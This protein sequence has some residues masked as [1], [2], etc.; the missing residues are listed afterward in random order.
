MAW[1]TLK[2]ESITKN[3][4]FS[5]NKD[6]CQK[7]DGEI[8]EEYFTV[9]RQDIVV[10]AA[11]TSKMEII[12][13]EQYRHPVKA[14][15]LELPA[16]YIETSDNNIKEAAERELLEETGY[17]CKTL[18]KICES[19]ASAG[20]SNNIISFFI[21][22]DARKIQKQNLDQSEELEVKPT[23]WDKA[24]QLLKQEKIKDLGSVAGILITAKHLENSDGNRLK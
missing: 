24:L 13:I 1:K 2:S 5:V 19:Y 7:T 17:K 16:G 23:S 14:V 21:G 10:I 3:R 22:F 15:D 8:V 4:H 18:K 11:F 20:F 9:E 6:K 12:L